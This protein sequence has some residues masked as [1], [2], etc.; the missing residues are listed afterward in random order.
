MSDA[1]FTS[2][3]SHGRGRFAL[4][5]ATLVLLTAFAQKA[6]AEERP[7][8]FSVSTAQMQALGIQLQR[9]DVK[10]DVAGLTYPGRVVVPPR[11]QQVVSAPLAGLV[12]QLLVSEND[13][14]KAGQPL[15]RV[16]SPEIGELQ[17]GLMEATSRQNLASKTL[18]RERQLLSE[19]IIPERRVQE[20]EAAA[21]EASARKRQAE[22]ALRLAGFD[23]GTIRK[24]AAGGTAVESGVVLRAKA[25]GLVTELTARPGQRVQQADKLMQ[26]ADT[27]T[28][29]IDVQVPVARQAEVATTKGAGIKLVGYD[30]VEATV[31]SIG[32]AVGDGQTVVLR[33]EVRS[34]AQSLRAGAFVQTRLPFAANTGWA[35]PI[36]AVAR[37]DGKAYVFVRTQGGFTATPVTVVSS[38]GQSLRVSGS[39][40]A[41]QQI[42]VTSVIALKAAWQ[43][44]GGGE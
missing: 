34:G 39:L 5:V 15:I 28:L 31:M 3:S 14:V 41:G 27:T 37:D 23:D 26:V 29:W 43:G 38:G 19:G 18:Q 40:Q 20:A 25:A 33:A 21:A 11:Q 6:R 2:S 30:D 44:K 1:L 32:S 13:R 24:L 7:S 12:D 8:A 16:L 9:L 10:A 42:A 22:A 36:G 35:V 4:A 17:L